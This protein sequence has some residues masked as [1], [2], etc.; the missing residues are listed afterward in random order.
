[1]YLCSVCQTELSMPVT[2]C[3]ACL[4]K[5][6]QCEEDWFIEAI[7]IEDRRRKSNAKFDKNETVFS[8][9]DIDT[10]RYLEETLYSY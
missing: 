8:D 3:G 9:L 10:K 7:K 4:K 5:Y 1:M 2:V 6:G